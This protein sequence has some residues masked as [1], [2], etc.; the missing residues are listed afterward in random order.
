MRAHQICRLR[1][2]LLRDSISPFFSIS[3][4]RPKTLSRQNRYDTRSHER[5]K[6]SSCYFNEH[7]FCVHGKGSVLE[8]KWH[9]DGE[10]YSDI[11]QFLIIQMVYICL[12]IFI[13]LK[14]C[15]SL[16]AVWRRWTSFFKYVAVHKR[17]ANVE[18][19]H[20]YITHLAVSLFR[21]SVAGVCQWTDKRNS[22]KSE[23]NKWHCGRF[24]SISSVIYFNIISPKLHVSSCE[25]ELRRDWI[26]HPREEK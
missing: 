9:G 24:F 25:V 13:S 21:L 8:R 15:Y 11:W 7:M 6:K 10:L 26:P 19:D 2:R 14:V 23:W 5:K 16:D 20:P 22:W 3:T 4:P 12:F 17:L 1:F 18:L